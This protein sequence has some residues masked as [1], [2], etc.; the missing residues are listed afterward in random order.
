MTDFLFFL[1]KILLSAGVGCI[2]Y[3]F[4]KYGVSE[5]YKPDLN[6][7]LVPVIIIIVSA[8]FIASIFFSVY[9]TAVD[10]LF[11]C[12]RKSITIRNLHNITFYL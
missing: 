4:F 9:S 7:E 5:I 6:Y 11:L 10:T 12:F 1:S 8:Y 2:A 3:V